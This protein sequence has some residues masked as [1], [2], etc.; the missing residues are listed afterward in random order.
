MGIV[1][2]ISIFFEDFCWLLESLTGQIWARWDQIMTK[3][4]MQDRV[5]RVRPVVIE[6][7]TSTPFFEPLS[8]IFQ[9]RTYA[10]S[11]LIESLA[12]KRA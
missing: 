11:S 12:W 1:I 7:K 2:V 5:E 9:D 4:G 3:Y 8:S 10:Y 6:G